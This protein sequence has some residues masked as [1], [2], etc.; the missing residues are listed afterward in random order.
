MKGLFG[1]EGGYLRLA[2]KERY[3][4]CCKRVYT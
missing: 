4:K 1:Q 3:K 2:V